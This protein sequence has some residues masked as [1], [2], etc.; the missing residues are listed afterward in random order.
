MVRSVCHTVISS[1]DTLG[2]SDRTSSVSS[3][4]PPPSLPPLVLNKVVP[5]C[6]RVSKRP[7]TPYLNPFTLHKI[8]P[9]PPLKSLTFSTS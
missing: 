3:E 2:K 5:S 4:E 9:T 1:S 6:L 8:T 7:R